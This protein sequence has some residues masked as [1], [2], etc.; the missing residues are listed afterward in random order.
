M[1][2]TLIHRII[3]LVRDA[4]REFASTD[5]IVNRF[6]DEGFSAD[7]VEDAIERAIN[8]GR[9]KGDVQRTGMIDGTIRVI[10]NIRFPQ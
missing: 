10:S 5:E 1:D 9:L 2:D 3:G 8:G 7:E 6:V 4:G